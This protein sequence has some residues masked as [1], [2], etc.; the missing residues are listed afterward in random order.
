MHKIYKCSGFIYYFALLFLSIIVIVPIGLLRD[1]IASGGILYIGFAVF[2]SLLSIYALFKIW[3]SRIIKIVVSDGSF[4]INKQ[5][6]SIDIRW[7]EILEFGKYRRRS[8]YNPGYWCF[9]F[10]LNKM[11]DKKIEIGTLDFK[12]RDE[13]ISTIFDKATN[14]KFITLEN[15]SW[16]PFVKRLKTLQWNQ[17][18]SL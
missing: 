12:E 3:Q 1:A 15:T 4:T 6:E 13:L 7:D 18:E 17:N 2:L 14:A 10:K 11:V 9:Y 16:F 5:F 8:A